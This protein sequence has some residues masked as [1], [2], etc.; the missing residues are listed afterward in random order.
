MS[1]ATWKAV[2]YPVPASQ[3]SKKH[4]ILASLQKWIG[5][6]PEN[7]SRHG[8]RKI[9]SCADIR[10]DVD[11][12]M[13]ICDSTCPLCHYYQEEDDDD[14]C[15]RDEDD[16]PPCGDCPLV[17]ILGTRCDKFAFSPWTVWVETGDPMPMIVALSEALANQG[18]FK[19]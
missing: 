9:V 16:L 10:D 17:E 13:Y 3:V 6:L 1:L 8:V 7:L 19:P 11:H 5:L 18:A 14:E 4:A 12:C 15:E 2:Y